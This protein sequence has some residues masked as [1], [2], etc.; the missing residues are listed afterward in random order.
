MTAFACGGCS[1]R[2]EDNSTMSSHSGRAKVRYS[3]LVEVWRW[4]G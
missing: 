2:C 3:I 1:D 4:S